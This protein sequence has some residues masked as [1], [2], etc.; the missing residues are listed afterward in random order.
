MRERKYK[1]EEEKEREH[2]ESGFE[3]GREEEQREAHL[4]ED[5]EKER[6]KINF[7]FEI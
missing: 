3:K 4:T 1:R 7:L 6:V 2:I 5:R